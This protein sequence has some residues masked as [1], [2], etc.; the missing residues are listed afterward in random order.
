MD[1][2]NGSLSLGDATQTLMNLDILYVKDVGYGMT[3]GM[4]DLGRLYQGY[5]VPPDRKDFEENEEQLEKSYVMWI[6]PLKNHEIFYE[7]AILSISSPTSAV[8]KLFFLI[9]K[10]WSIVNL[11]MQWIL[12]TMEYNFLW[13]CGIFY[14]LEAVFLLTIPSYLICELA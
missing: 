8:S 10:L 5:Y 14:S 12:F 4:M 11:F 9:I 7:W 3:R 6:V 1:I 2:Q 13:I